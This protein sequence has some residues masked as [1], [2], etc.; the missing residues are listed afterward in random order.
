MFENLLKFV[1]ENENAEIENSDPEIVTADTWCTDG[2]FEEI[3][4]PA[5]P[6]SELTDEV[7]IV[8]LHEFKE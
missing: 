5:E 7:L 6:Q 4:E 3:K 8:M 2:E 1:D